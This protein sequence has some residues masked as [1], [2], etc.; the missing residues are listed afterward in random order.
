VE[1]AEGVQ[2]SSGDMGAA[3]ISNKAKTYVVKQADETF[4]D[5]MSII[6]YSSN[7]L[8]NEIKKIQERP[9]TVEAE[10]GVKIT[11]EGKAMIVSGK[12]EANYTVKLSWKKST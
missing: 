6:S 2:Q 9:E 5:A 12:V 10:F 3:S 11:G 8:L 4:S 7:T 1:T